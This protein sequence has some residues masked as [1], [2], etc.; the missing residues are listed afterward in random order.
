VR[1]I[2]GN[3]EAIRTWKLP[4]CK[5]D[6]IRNPS[7]LVMGLDE[8]KTGD[9][10][11]GQQPVD[12]FCRFREI[13]ATAVGRCTDTAQTKNAQFQSPKRPGKSKTRNMQARCR[14][15]PTGVNC[16]GSR[17]D[18]S[19]HPQFHILGG[20]IE[21][22]WNGRREMKTTRRSSSSLWLT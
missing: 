6:K 8:M 9:D 4:I 5:E 15:P 13:Q 7:S 11:L 20:T 10:E 18:D 14:Q 17:M 22:I 21:A 2:L 3:P 12:S 1:R 16:E 19:V